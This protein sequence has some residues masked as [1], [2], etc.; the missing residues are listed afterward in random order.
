LPEEPVDVLLM[1]AELLRH[2]AAREHVARHMRSESSWRSLKGDR[3]ND[4]CALSHIA[5]HLLVVKSVRH[6]L[7]A[8]EAN[9]DGRN[10]AAKKKVLGPGSTR[11][12]GMW[13]ARMSKAV[14][15]A[16]WMTGTAWAAGGPP[17]TKLIN[18]A[19]SRNLEPGVSLW[20]AQIYNDNFLLFGVLVV[21]VMVVQG[22][23]FGFGFDRLMHWIGIDLGKLSH[24]E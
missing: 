3:R 20:I 21:V 8:R 15:S 22:L 24:E 6:E 19:D 17:A 4:G 2:L 1:N 14:V 5:D 23:V 16:A 13:L 18:I 10:V 7:S 12:A 9:M 11:S